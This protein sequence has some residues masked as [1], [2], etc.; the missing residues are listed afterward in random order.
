MTVVGERDDGECSIV[1][2]QGR[3]E[4]IVWLYI[5]VLLIVSFLLSTV[6]FLAGWY[7]SKLWYDRVRA[8]VLVE[9]A[10]P[11]ARA[12]RLVRRLNA[13]TQCDRRST[14]LQKIER[15]T[16]NAIR[17]ELRRFGDMTDGSKIVLAERL[18]LRRIRN[19]EL[20]GLHADDDPI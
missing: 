6:C 19:D 17:D 13:Y 4:G 15:L 9:R 1:L 5:A 10:R 7:L 3:S 12:G 2:A 18:R 20:A 14:D 8:P 16:I 11:K